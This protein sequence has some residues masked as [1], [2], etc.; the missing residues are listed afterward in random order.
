MGSIGVNEL[1]EALFEIN[2]IHL[3]KLLYRALKLRV[4][5]RLIRDPVAVDRQKN[6]DPFLHVR[7]FCQCMCRLRND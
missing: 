6:I 4:K 7:H 3:G 1:V 2:I 5:N